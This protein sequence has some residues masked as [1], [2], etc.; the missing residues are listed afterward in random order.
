MVM[1]EVVWPTVWIWSRTLEVVLQMVTVTHSFWLI[2]DS[3][4]MCWGTII[5]ERTETM[6]GEWL[7]SEDWPKWRVLIDILLIDSL[8]LCTLLLLLFADCRRCRAVDQTDHRRRVETRRALR[9]HV[10]QGK[11]SAP[12]HLPFLTFISSFTN[13]STL[14]AD[15]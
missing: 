15:D 5:E 14:L 8:W 11:R 3:C 4:H 7:K 13:L 10:R 9:F 12:L 6:F 2:V 1:V